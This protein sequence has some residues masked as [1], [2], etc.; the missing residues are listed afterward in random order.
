MDIDAPRLGLELTFLPRKRGQWQEYRDEDEAKLVA[1]TLNAAFAKDAQINTAR[2]AEG[3][4]TSAPLFRAKADPF[5][6]MWC[7]NQPHPA[8]CIEIVNQPIRAKSILRDK[9]PVSLALE[10]VYKH[11]RR[12]GLHPHIE[13]RQKRGPVLDYPTG[14][15]HIHV[16]LMGL[17]G[18]SSVY[19]SHLK[20]LEMSLCLDLVNLPLIRWLFCQWSDNDNSTTD[21]DRAICAAAD[22]ERRKQRLS[23]GAMANWAYAEVLAGSSF[24]QRFTEGYKPAQM[25]TWEMRFF[26]MPRTVAELRLQV[27]FVSGWITKRVAQIDAISDESVI[28][29]R[30]QMSAAWLRDVLSYRL[31]VRQWDRFTK[32]ERY[33]K[34][35]MR[36]FLRGLDLD[37]E[38]YMAAFWA[39]GYGRRRRFGSFSGDSA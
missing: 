21:V 22:K 31:T 38:P 4:N 2:F 11:C 9:S 27:A 36:T 28:R 33:A 30:R 34:A 26:D 15:G 16:S 19:L 25:F 8:W 32:D 24:K 23:R 12:L 39:R 7:P 37:P 1:S 5:R 3:G 18:S 6:V 13:R 29:K 17:W 20:A 10:A 35:A 14:G